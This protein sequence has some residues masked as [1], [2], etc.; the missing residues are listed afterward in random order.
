MKDL[1]YLQVISEEKSISRSAKRLHI[2]HQSL[3]E[4][5]DN[6]EL[7]LGVKILV[8]TPRGVSF[9]KEGRR[10]VEFAK[11]TIEEY[12]K[13]FNEIK[14]N[15][16][17]VVVQTVL[18]I[19]GSARFCETVLFHYVEQFC[20]IC[21]NIK[22]DI[23]LDN[24]DHIFEQLA[25]SL[26]HGRSAI[27][28]T[29]VK[30]GKKNEVLKRAESYG[31]KFYSIARSELVFLVGKGH[32]LAYV[33]EEYI[34]TILSYPFVHFGNDV[35]Q[36]DEFFRDFGNYIPEMITDSYNGWWN[37]LKDDNRVGYMYDFFLNAKENIGQR[38]NSQFQV[39][40]SKEKIIADVGYVLAEEPNEIENEFIQF[41]L[42]NI[43]SM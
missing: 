30:L 33:G 15:I 12:H 25:D 18:G 9:T 32:P 23:R 21:P 2:S 42:K 11:Q 24:S 34:A 6:L 43:K 27:G 41:L 1:Y 14:G 3:G 40:R 17:E 26:A 10:L 31:E 36:A 37:L 5:L 38:I 16:K 7:K 13:V 35:N 20:A 22:I 29:V 28:F 4:T 8:R 39:I 19:Y